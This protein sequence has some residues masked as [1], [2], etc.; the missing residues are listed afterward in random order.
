MNSFPGIIEIATAFGVGFLTFISPCVL[1][2]I[3]SYLAYISGTSF[4]DLSDETKAAK[5]RKT[6][7]LHSLSFVIGFT[8][9]FVAL[10]ATATLIGSFLRNHLNVIIK[11]AGAVVFFFG[12]HLA[13]ILKLNLLMKDHRVELKEKPAGFIGSILVGMAFAA[14]WTPCVGPLLGT[15]LTLASTKDTVTSGIILLS[16]FA[17]GLGVPF[18]IASIAFGSFL[19]YTMKF[20]RYLQ[21]FTTAAGVFLMI[22]GITLFMGWFGALS[23]LLTR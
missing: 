1:P 12:L 3:P 9:I 2:I 18:I 11:I 21:Y 16:V 23:G 20:K 10:G 13:G 5:L 7:F 6:I 19:K 22:I 4:D 8:L 15:A 17:L 14:G